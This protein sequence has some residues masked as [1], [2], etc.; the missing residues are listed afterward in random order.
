[1]H[2]NDWIT[3]FWARVERTASCWLWT[4][5]T[6]KYG[7]GAVSD[8]GKARRAHRVAWELTHGAIPAGLHVCHQCD[9]PQ[10]V[11]PAHLFLGTQQQNMADMVQKGR[12]AAARRPWRPWVLQAFALHADGLNQMAIAAQLG[13]SQASVSRAL[14]GKTWK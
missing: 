6:F 2:T 1:M 14:A 5:G 12:H 10:C 8:G 11:N 7:Y 9:N 3:H 4:G 13:V